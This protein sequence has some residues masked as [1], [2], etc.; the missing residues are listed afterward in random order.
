MESGRISDRPESRDVL[1]VEDEAAVRRAAFEF[2]SSIGYKVLGAA[3]GL[4]AL[5]VARSQS[6]PIH[7]LVTDVVM[8]NMSGAQLAEQLLKE[9]PGVKVLFVSGYAEKTVLQ[10]GDI[11]LSARFLQKP[12]TLK[13]LGQK[14]RTTL[15]S[16]RDEACPS[17]TAEF[18]A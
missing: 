15:E 14:I 5:D 9:R 4:Q 10:H 11:D 12:F 16:Q 17:V 1:L 13:A 6:G 3:D 18:P 7:I 8:P 2:L